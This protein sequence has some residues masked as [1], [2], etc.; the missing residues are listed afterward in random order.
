MTRSW[1]EVLLWCG[2][3]G[4][5]LF[6][7]VWLIEGAMRPGYDPTRLP[8]SLLALTDRGWVQTLNFLTA[9]ALMVAFAGG[10]WRTLARSGRVAKAGSILFAVFGASLV[11]AGLFSAD[12]G[13]GY[14]PGVGASSSTAGALHDVATLIIF[15]SLIAACALLARSFL[16]AGDRRWAWY[17]AAA[18]L[19]T[20]AGFVL[21]V[22]AFSGRNDLTPIGG[23]VQRLTVL[24]GWSWI[25]LLA[26]RL[27][28]L[29]R[30]RPTPDRDRNG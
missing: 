2:A 3:I 6:V 20:F 17:S 14:P 29:E 25:T 26:A 1:T 19:F 30:A 24:G 5:S 28:K 4:A 8:I 15:A 21:M 13:G 16:V 23:L 27:L 12:P 18:A 11:G 22:Y 10:L 9:G 7:L